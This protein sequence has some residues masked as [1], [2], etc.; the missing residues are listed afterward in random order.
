MA[1]KRTAARSSP[2]AAAPPDAGRRDRGSDRGSDATPIARAHPRLRLVLLAALAGLGFGLGWL[3]TGLA[4]LLPLALVPLLRGLRRAATGRDAALL[5]AVFAAA[6]VV[7]GAHYILV[8]LTYSPLAIVL[9]VLDVLYFLPFDVL[10]AWGSIWIE[11]RVGVPRTL[12]FAPV[13]TA[14][15]WAR[16]QTDLSNG[17]AMIAHAF[18]VEPAW[19]AWSPWTGPFFLSLL[20]TVVGALLDLAFE[21]RRRPARAAALA[22][23]AVALWLAPPATDLVAPAAPAAPGTTLR[24]GIVQ[25]SLTVEQKLDRR[26]WP[27]TWDLMKR[28]TGEAAQGADLVIWP[29]SARPGPILWKEGEPFADPPMEEIARQVGVPILYGCEIATVAGGRVTALYNSA[30]LA[31]AD[32]TP[33]DWYHKQQ[34]LPFAEGVPFARWIGWD[35]A[36][37]RRG[38]SGG[39]S[40]LT[41][42]GNFTPGTRPT[43]F[44][45]GAA[46]I[47]VLICFEGMYPELARRY[48]L[49]GANAL[50][51]M[52]ND[53]WWGR[54][55]FASWHARMASSRARELD[56][57]VVRAANSGVSSI[58]DRRGRMG[59]HTELF[60]TTTLKV[61]LEP[62]DSPPTLYARR[63]ELLVGIDLAVLAAAVAVGLVRGR[64]R[65]AAGR[66]APR[67]R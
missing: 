62:S 45:V 25:P 35:P 57:P 27:E 44:R 61:P 4:P 59:P 56:L 63:G 41:L 51:V 19:L 31:R 48:R 66:R 17:S 42:A 55:V 67:G 26:R 18:G 46:R 3:P 40:Y 2:G 20:A 12:A 7:V 49:E 36:T 14:L 32:G 34:L 30:A 22:A 39:R 8:L 5:G 15:E 28:L 29:E 33:G 9:L 53:A 11:R 58:T 21:N 60:A 47:G 23:A 38:G 50:C 1:T 24:V 52:T 64:R 65:D 16:T 6:R 37:A 13:F 10:N 43:V 54:S